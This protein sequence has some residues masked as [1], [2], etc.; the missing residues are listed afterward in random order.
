VVAGHGKLDDR[1]F[2]EVVIRG[3]DPKSLEKFAVTFQEFPEGVK[4]ESFSETAGSGEEK[5]TGVF[6]DRVKPFG[7]INVKKV[8]PDDFVKNL[9]FAWKF[10]HDSLLLAPLEPVAQTYVGFLR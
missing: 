8:I 9:A 10:Q 6:Y 7:L 3:V 1:M 5:T 2:F 4:Q